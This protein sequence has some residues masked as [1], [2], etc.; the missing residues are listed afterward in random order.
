M[1]FEFSSGMLVYR[2][3]EGVREFLFL[4]K[5]NGRLDMP[6]GHIEKGESA[7]EA[8]IR[9]TREES[10]IETRPSGFFRKDVSYRF[11]EKGI[12]IKKRV[13]MFMAEVPAD[14][15]VR[16][17][18]EHAGYEWLD[19]KKALKRV[20]FKNAKD[21]L[22]GVEGYIGREEKM[23]SLNSE[24]MKLPPAEGW[25]LSRNFV[26]GEGAVDARIM[27]IGQAPG[28]EEDISRRPFT[29]RSG[30]F[31]DR[32][33]RIARLERGSV[34]ITSVVQFF[35]PKNRVPT[36]AEIA[37]CKPFLK[38]QIE[39]VEPKI[40]VLLGALAAREMLGIEGI[41]KYRGETIERDG[42]KYFVSL[43]PA[44]A[45]RIR[46]NIRVMEG[47]FRK[48]GRIAGGNR[49]RHNGRRVT[50]PSSS[51]GTVSPP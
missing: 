11:L 7:Q 44:A 51:S 47:D 35:P 20:R 1:R 40:I 8:A 31:L 50:L 29:G 9:E 19:I 17:S 10:G 15:E 42:I 30:R 41:S 28:A 23:D 3:K 34:Y 32:L 16:I 24:Y 43:H 36:E 26:P 14:T 37:L 13:T 49:K 38:R 46:K 33:L 22:R 5:A 4:K 2:V 21:L 39:I 45:I 27:F 12:M 48:L 6:K 25:E 18:D